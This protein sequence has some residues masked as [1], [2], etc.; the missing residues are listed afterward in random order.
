M[1]LGIL[2]AVLLAAQDSLRILGS[3]EDSRLHEAQRSRDLL[4]SC[5]DFNGYITTELVFRASEVHTIHLACD[6]ELARQITIRFLP[7]ASTVGDLGTP[8]ESAMEAFRIFT[9][10][11][12]QSLAATTQWFHPT[13][14][15]LSF[16][17]GEHHMQSCGSSFFHMALP[18]MHGTLRLSV[19]LPAETG[20][21]TID[22]DAGDDVPMNG[23]PISGDRVQRLL[24]Q[25]A[26]ANAMAQVDLPVS[27]Y[28]TDLHPARIL[29]IWKRQ[30]RDVLALHV[31]SANRNMLDERSSA[32]VSFSL[33]GRHYQFTTQTASVVEHQLG[34]HAMLSLIAFD[35]P[36]ELKANEQRRVFRVTPHPNTT[37][38]ILPL[39]LSESG[40]GAKGFTALVRDLSV[41]GAGIT[42]DDASIVERVRQG[43]FVLCRFGLPEEWG[44]VE[45]PAVVRYVRPYP[46]A[47]RPG[48][49]VGLKFLSDPL[50][51]AYQ[52]GLETLCRYAYTRPVEGRRRASEPVQ[53]PTNGSAGKGDM[54]SSIAVFS[55]SFDRCRNE[56]DFF[57]RFYQ[58]FIASSPEVQKKFSGTDF[59][60]QGKMLEEGLVLLSA[61]KTDPTVLNKLGQ[62]ADRH[63]RRDL[64]IRPELYGLFT[65]ILV[66]TVADTDPEYSAEVQRAWETILA[67][68]VAFMKR[69][70]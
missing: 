39:Y 33:R 58:R 9:G 15:V 4:L 41:L 45:V 30:N 24:A 32:L 68:G 1:I 65:K 54:D 16:G 56:P 11:F 64:D 23:D 29:G 3:G 44:N 17:P 8:G 36:Q 66:K 38:D 22:R 50:W 34:D 28:K 5:E 25:G 47:G 57:Q 21:G 69:R 18:A 37:A 70:Y 26:A 35:L 14:D 43:Q 6:E 20:E 40:Q 10:I 42:S 63:G 55:A 48:Y 61:L 7:P 52:Q 2:Q 49:R 60:K 51:K 53:V 12:Q 67:H 46:S 62:I 27:E 19:A 13:D 59:S 31:P